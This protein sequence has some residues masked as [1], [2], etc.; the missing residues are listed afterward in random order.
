MNGRSNKKTAYKRAHD[1]VAAIGT[2]TI[3]VLILTSAQIPHP[4]YWTIALAISISITS[5]WIQYR[6]RGGKA[7]SWKSIMSASLFGLCII[8]LAL[9]SKLLQ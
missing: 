1:A 6:K 5:T 4:V 7:D 2:I 8:L 3:V 9:C